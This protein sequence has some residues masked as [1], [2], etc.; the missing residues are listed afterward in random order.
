MFGHRL[1]YGIQQRLSIN[2]F[3]N[4]SVHTDV[5]IQSQIILSQH[6]G[7]HNDWSSAL[8]FPSS[9]ALTKDL[10]S[11]KSINRGQLTSD[12]DQ[13]KIFISRN[14]DY[15][16][17][18]VSASHNV[19]RV[20]QDFARFFSYLWDCIFC[21]VCLCVSEREREREREKRKK[22]ERDSLARCTKKSDI[23]PSM[24]HLKESSQ[25]ISPYVEAR[26]AF[27]DAPQFETTRLHP[28]LSAL[29]PSMS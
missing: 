23:P 9:L 21:C 1:F 19:L 5:L 14:L 17:T 18:I 11:G 7:E 28:S 15:A 3:G 2:G 22:K 10:R 26:T 12:Q 8:A 13:I 16:L 20:F 29:L 4:T 27:L 24:P 6:I 25:Y